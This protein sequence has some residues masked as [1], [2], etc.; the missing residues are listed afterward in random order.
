MHPV[1]A[2]RAQ[3]CLKY[4]YIISQNRHCVKKKEAKKFTSKSPLQ[5]KSHFWMDKNQK[6]FTFSET[7]EKTKKFSLSGNVNIIYGIFLKHIQ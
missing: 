6:K 7:H 3:L 1:R 5:Q 4:F 2:N